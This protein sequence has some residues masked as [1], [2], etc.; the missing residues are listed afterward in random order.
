MA[1][2]NF[3]SARDELQA[4]QRR[5]NDRLHDVKKLRS[6]L[7]A[8]VESAFCA[9][10]K[11]VDPATMTLLQSGILTVNEYSRLMDDAK[12]AGNFTMVRLIG[13]ASADAAKTKGENDP[14]AGELRALAHRS[15]ENPGD[16]I[17]GNFDA[18]A[19]AFTRSTKNPG[20]IDHW[21]DLCSET[22]ENF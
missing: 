19:D 3:Y 22:V 21:N 20:L 7:A 6:E 12:S 9:D 1:Q 10:P 8:A 2:A 16:S 17:L 15:R 18:L 13:K 4:T 5:M 14:A 11:A